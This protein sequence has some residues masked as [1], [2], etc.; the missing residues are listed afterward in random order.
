MWS[1]Y[2]KIEYNSAELKHVVVTGHI[3]IQ[4]INNFCKEI[5]HADHGDL[6]TNTVII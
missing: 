6:S 3:S 5:F 1:V 2:K 4:A